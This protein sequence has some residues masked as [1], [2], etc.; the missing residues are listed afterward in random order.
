MIVRD[1]LTGVCDDTVRDTLTG[2]CDDT[3]RD[4]LT[5]MC[6]DSVFVLHLLACVMYDTVHVLHDTFIG[7][8]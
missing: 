6:D 1:T 8:P 7:S 3:V 5:G 4:T 2:M